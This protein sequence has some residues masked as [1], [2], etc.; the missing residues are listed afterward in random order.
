MLVAP[1][2]AEQEAAV[3]EYRRVR[4]I[5]LDLCRREDAAFARYFARL[6]AGL[7]TNGAATSRLA[8]LA[9]YAS[10]DVYSAQGALY[11]VG[12]EPWDIDDADRV[13]RVP[14]S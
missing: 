12:I 9:N 10:T 11:K 6:H 7:R 14:V 3:A 8:N 1:L 2:T 4:D 5:Y 13:E